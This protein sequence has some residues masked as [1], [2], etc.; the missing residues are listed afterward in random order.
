M[1]VKT[2][3]AIMIGSAETELRIYEL[4]PRKG[5]REIDR[6]STRLNLG[7]DA[8]TM[9]KLSAEKVQYLCEILKHFKTIMEGY[10]AEAY[11]ICATSAFREIRS[12]L[13]TKDYIEKQT[14]MPIR[15]L[16][17]SEQRFLDY[18]SIASE[19]SSFENIIKN[20]TA[21]VDIGGNSM[22]ISVFDNDKL[23]TTQNIRMGKISTREHYLPVSKNRHHYESMIL[24]LLDHEL[25]GFAKLYQKERQILNLIIADHDLLDIAR[26]QQENHSIGAIMDNPDLF[27]LS[28]EQFGHLYER[29]MD[30]DTDDMA[31]SLDIPA[32]SAMLVVQSLIF[33]RALQQRME[34]ETLWIMDVSLCDG[35]CYD[36]GVANK[37]ITSRHNFEDDIIAA[38]RNIAKRY[39]S[40]QP[41]VKAVEEL[42]LLIFNRMK[43]I[44]GLKQR[45][46]LMLQIAAILHN[47]GKYISLTNVADCAYNIVMATEII[48]LSHRE[49]RIIANV[50]RFNTAEFSY[51]EVMD[52]DGDISREE[53]IVIA[54]LTAMLR[55]A[56]ALDSSHRQKC[57][58]ASV[59]LKD[60]E[61]VITVNTQEDLSL[62]MVSL[63]DRAEFFEEVFNIH[64]VL[65]QK[66]KM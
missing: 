39:K 12:S 47:C 25:A 32:D 43:K 56:N 3:A 45:E 57:K 44:H 40:S 65:H 59:T 66:K 33:C 60:N 7:V 48:G 54:K 46:R 6:V 50:V 26:R 15:I 42:A 21:I 38:S 36:Y 62:E 9:G 17:N 14:Q 37:L 52:R 19:S 28:A 22:Q 20:G 2:Y 13:I 35:L 29:V 16:S 27:H 10:Q 18:K 63:K 8:Y 53:Y 55:V 61:L 58:D 30:M 51:D 41:H 23:V 1:A 34:A 11:S 64:P 4:S 5:M 24:D 49:R 31:T